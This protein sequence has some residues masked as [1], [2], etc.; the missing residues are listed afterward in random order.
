MNIP[1]Q[2]RDIYLTPDKIVS[3][4]DQVFF[5]NGDDGVH[6]WESGIVLARF[7]LSINPYGSLLELGSGSGLA[8]I[9][10]VKYTQ[11]SSVT[12]TDY[13]RK[14][15]DNITNN[16]Q[17]NSVSAAVRYLDWTD[18]STYTNTHDIVIGSDLIYDGAPIEMLI[19]T[20]LHHLSANAVCYI[21]MPDKR[22]MTP[23]FLSLASEKGLTV[24]T[25][26]LKDWYTS[27]P[28]IDL[29]KGFREFAELTMRKYILYTL[30]K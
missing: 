10:A 11:I 20:I 21:V 22:K 12:L 23:V 7:I 5:S 28:N 29:N 25:Q 1:P 13:N 4:S 3:V 2:L 30:K 8:G 14:V 18:A 9:A 15:L 24:E 19:N 6:Q 17:R 27:S 16:L 26:E